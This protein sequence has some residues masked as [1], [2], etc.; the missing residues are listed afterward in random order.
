MPA[1]VGRGDKGETWHPPFR[2]AT[3]VIIERILDRRTI[4]PLTG[5]TDEELLAQLA[6]QTRIM[7]EHEDF[8][9]L[10]SKAGPSLKDAII[11]GKIKKS[12][13]QV[14][15]DGGIS[16]LITRERMRSPRTSAVMLSS[17]FLPKFPLVSLIR[18]YLIY[19]TLEAED[20]K[21]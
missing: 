1:R 3:D 5:F 14:Q 16:K 13:K 15:G 2:D 8:E 20:L 21:K 10:R 6:E 12:K 9:A 11:P 4:E 17:S 18:N 19:Q 7:E